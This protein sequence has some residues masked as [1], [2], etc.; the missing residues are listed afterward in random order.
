MDASELQQLYQD[1]IVDHN[2]TPRNFR[3]IE[4]CDARA[5]CRRA[6]G[7]NPLC[8]DKL[9]LYLDLEDGRV[10]DAAFQGSGCAISVASASLL[11]EAVRGRSEDEVHGLFDTMRAYLTGQRALDDALLSEI[12]KLSAL[13]GVAAFPM[14]VKCATLCWHTLEAALAGE[15]QATTE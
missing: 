4:P 13:G 1:V 3:R 9:E 6:D 2:R 5:G 10:A 11:T 8:G 12:G 14:R 15:Q 7:F